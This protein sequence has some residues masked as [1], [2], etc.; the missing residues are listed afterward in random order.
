MHQYFSINFKSEGAQG[1]LYDDTAGAGI[2]LICEYATSLQEYQYEYRSYSSGDPGT[3]Y[4]MNGDGECP[5][6]EWMVGFK[7]NIQTDSDSDD[8]GLVCIKIL[9]SDGTELEPVD[10]ESM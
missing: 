3:W 10:C 6:G 4:G 5:T 2:R 8:T 1:G 9:C 7:T